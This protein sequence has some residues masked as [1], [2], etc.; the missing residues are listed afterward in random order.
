MSF[1]LITLLASRNC[2]MSSSRLRFSPNMS[3]S[4]VLRNLATSLYSF[5]KSRNSDALPSRAFARA[6]ATGEYFS[7]A[8]SSKALSYLRKS[9]TFILLLLAL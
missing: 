4:P 8:F 2:L 6:C 5:I 7:L 9:S 3:L 1:S